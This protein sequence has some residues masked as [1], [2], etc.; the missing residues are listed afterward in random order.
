MKVY[1]IPCHE[2]ILKTVVVLQNCINLPNDAPGSHSETCCAGVEFINVKVEEMTDI[3]DD[4][5]PV[6]ISSPAIKGEHEVSCV[7][8]Y[9]VI[10]TSQISSIICCLSHLHSHE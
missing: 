7:C 3:E 4:E 10:H 5:S 6:S 9:F 2:K 1:S 8:A